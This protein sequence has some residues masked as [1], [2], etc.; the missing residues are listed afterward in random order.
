[1]I[2]SVCAKKIEPIHLARQRSLLKAARI[3]EGIC[4]NFHA[5]S[6]AAEVKR[7]SVPSKP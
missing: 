4:L 6:M 3:E 1:M 2:A 5:E 7:F